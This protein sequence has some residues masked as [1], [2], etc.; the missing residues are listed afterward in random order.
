[1]PNL[2]DLA[3][4]VPAVGFGFMGVAALVAP[5]RV[6]GL[7]GI[8]PLEVDGRSEVRAVYGG[9]GLAIAAALALALLQPDLR[10]GVCVTVA[11][12]LAGMAG[13]RL[14]SVTIDRAVGP[15]PRLFFVLELL[16]ASALLY[17]AG[18]W[19]S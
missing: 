5:S 4:L 13:G 2:T 18:P 9:F 7:F 16:L 10:A 8:P 12:A 14:V 1:M 3:V 15:A 11:A 19:G 17:G 6:T